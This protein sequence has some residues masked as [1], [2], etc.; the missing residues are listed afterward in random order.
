MADIIKRLSELA[1]TGQASRNGVEFARFINRI[2]PDEPEDVLMC[3]Y[4]VC[5][6]IEDSHTCLPI[7]RTSWAHVTKRY[8][9]NIACEIDINHIRDSRVIGPPDANR[10]LIL[11]E[12]KIYLHRYYHY[13]RIIAQ[14]ILSMIKHPVSTP[15]SKEEI[16]E[17]I[18]EKLFSP[19]TKK[20]IS[21]DWQKIAVLHSLFNRLL[22]ISGGPGTGK[23]RTVTAIMAIL[24]HLGKRENPVTIAMCAPTGKAAARLAESVKA[25]LQTM[26]DYIQASLPTTA[27]TIHRLLGA[28]TGNFRY[29]RNNP[30]PYD[31][32]IVDEVSM[33][34]MPLMAHLFDALDK[35]TSLIMLGDKDQLA[36]VE[37]GCVLGDIC[38]GI[39]SYRYSDEFMERCKIIREDTHLKGHGH[40][41]PTHRLKDAMIHLTY[42]YRFDE[43]SGIAQL[44]KAVN[45]GDYRQVKKIL[46]EAGKK[47]RDIEF[48]KRHEK[49]LDALLKEYFLPYA[50]S[51]VTAPTVTDAIE[52]MNNAKIL[53]GLR[54]GPRGIEYINRLIT[55]ILSGI[56]MPFGFIRPDFS[57]L[58][59]GLPIIINKNDYS[60]ELFNGDTGIVWPDSNGEMKVWF[61]SEGGKT[62]G[63]LPARLP[64]HD[65][66]WAIT[67]HRSQGSEFDNVYF[68]LPPEDSFMPG[69]ELLYTAITRA[70]DTITLWGSEDDMKTCVEN[71]TLRY[72]G[73]GEMLWSSKEK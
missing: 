63:I 2:A 19:E 42:S 32:V 41:L 35:E 27:K 66:A 45:I 33:V 38:S 37:A 62:R 14:R 21:P 44:S 9:C 26:P 71:K 48:I 6:A 17:F 3:A 36:S 31:I 43:K 25:A 28:G 73:L 64:S 23:T 7:D 1:C 15:S 10:P 20:K 30:L 53:C 18:T 34:D 49:P 40:D 22:I 4:L 59:R 11:Y 65:H 70:R 57:G 60:L 68:I 5:A 61:I 52:L 8:C 13:E 16:E 72:S 46:S 67:V 29:D 50:R 54:K 12:D 58:Y 51:I 69:R 24:S 56:E 47:Y 55:I 39:G